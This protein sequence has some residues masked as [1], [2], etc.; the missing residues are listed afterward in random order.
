MGGFRRGSSETIFRARYR[1]SSAADPEILR[2]GGWS[3]EDNVSRNFKK[4][5]LECGR[6]CIRPVVIYRKCTQRTICLLYGK[7]RFTEKKIRAD[8]VALYCPSL[9]SATARH[10]TPLRW[11]F[12]FTL[13]GSTPKEDRK[14]EEKN[15]KH[16]YGIL[17]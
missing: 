17:T 12:N 14:Q 16:N 13:R 11:R 1:S 7:R 9:E 10:M 8:G 5:R 3:A 6:Q 4:G 2:R 15:D